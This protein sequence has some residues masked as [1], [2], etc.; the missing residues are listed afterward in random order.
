MIDSIYFKIFY[1]LASYLLGSVLFAYIMAKIFGRGKNLS[2]IDRPGTAGAGRQYG[3]KASIPTFIFDV[4]KGV[5][6]PLVAHLIGLDRFT[7]VVATI[8]VLVGHNWPIFFKFKG[9]GG[10][11]T[12]IGIAAY[13]IPV[14]FLISFGISLAVGFTYKY[15]LHKKKHQVN[16]NV[17]G[18]A[19]GTFLLPVLCFA[20][21]KPNYLIILFFC[22]FLIIFTKGLILHF[23]YRNNPTAN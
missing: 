2:E 13:L 14:I 22:L 18:G 10:I 1:V 19:L 20:F 17:V 11:A 8:A 23:M 4:G 12:T 16:P 6:V 5:A 9:G 7:M 15:T 21:S 3:Y